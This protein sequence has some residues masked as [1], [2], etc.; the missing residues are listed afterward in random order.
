MTVF[1]TF[2]SAGLVGSNSW[3]TLEIDI[4]CEC[5]D[6]MVKPLVQMFGE[7]DEE[8]KVSAFI[9]FCFSQTIRIQL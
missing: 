6:D 2:K 3:E 1:N 8:K 7:K 4:I 5:C 9:T